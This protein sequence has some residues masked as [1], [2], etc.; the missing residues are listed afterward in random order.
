M[1]NK[2]V[3]TIT[4]MIR[5]DHSRVIA[6]FHQYDIDSRPRVK[7]ALVNTVCLALEIHAQLEEEIFYPALRAVMQGNAMLDDSQPQ[8]DAMRQSITALRDMTPTDADYDERFMQLMQ[9]V[10]HHVADEE[11][12]LLPA[13]ERLLCDSLDELGAQMT[14]RRL[15]LAAPHALE[16]ASHSVRGM[17]AKSMLLAA[18]AVI[19][20][21]YVLRRSLG[22]EA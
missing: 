16:I 19:A 2:S 5:I 14:K 12:T 20:G 8:H 17:P 11:T 13:A 22:R 9:S 1:K 7:Q 10:L 21:G 18:G 3:P 15:Q 6:A 4:N